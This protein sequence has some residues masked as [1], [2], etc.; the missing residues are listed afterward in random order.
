MICGYVL[1]NYGD[2]LKQAAFIALDVILGYKI[3]VINVEKNL[4]HTYSKRIRS[5]MYVISTMVRG[6]TE[7]P[8][9]LALSFRAVAYVDPSDW[10]DQTKIWLMCTKSFYKDFTREE[11]TDPFAKRVPLI[12]VVVDIKPSLPTTIEVYHREGDYSN[13]VYRKTKLE[14]S[15]L[16]PLQQ[17]ADILYRIKR[18]YEQ[19]R[20]ATIFLNGSPGTGKSS[21]GYLLAKHLN[22][23]FCHSFNPTE[24]GD[25][26]SC[27]IG[28]AQYSSCETPIVIVLEEANMMI[29]KIHKGEVVRS[30]KV[31]TSVYDKT[32]WSNFLDDMS[33]YKQV[34]LILT[35][36]EPKE[37][38]DALDPAYLRRGRVDATFT[39]NE[40]IL[41]D[42]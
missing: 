33:L 31:P 30:P 25:T 8:Y 19:K 36:N 29:R 10:H 9:H 12:E 42:V 17:Q 1:Y 41:L 34:V 20:R 27:L 35:S 14:V 5:S 4:I 40:E 28:S 16:E 18:I 3:Y 15:T 21:I 7:I 32:T 37:A 11:E 39:M 24:P 6:Q 38:I 26:V 13:L 22:G 23:S 2:A